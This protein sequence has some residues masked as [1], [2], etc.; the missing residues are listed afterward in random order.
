MP[1]KLG[2]PELAVLMVLMLENRSVL[3]TELNDKVRL[4]KAGRVKLNKAGLIRTDENVK[5]MVHEITDEGITR[6]VDDLIE[7]ELPPRT[8]SYARAGFALLRKLIKHHNARGTLVEVIR[9]RD[10]ESLIR[11]VY[12][13]L[14]VEP[15]DWIRLARIRPR[16]NG[17][18]KGEVDD[19]LVKMM[20]TGTVHL[21]PESNTK[22]LTPDD[23]AAAL[24]LGNEDLHLVA[25]EES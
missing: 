11:S 23:H 9:S 6:C 18:E 7:G 10:L 24:R 25:M 19:A 15:Q 22:V 14:A 8:P 13:E 21:A 16:L 12:E 3:N 20:K 17:A 1:E 5:P 4:T 2:A